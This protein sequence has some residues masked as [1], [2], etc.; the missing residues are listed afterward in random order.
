MDAGLLLYEKALASWNPSDAHRRFPPRYDGLPS[1]IDSDG[2]DPLR[3]GA[4][5]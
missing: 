2:S 5:V 3:G 1:G 4:A